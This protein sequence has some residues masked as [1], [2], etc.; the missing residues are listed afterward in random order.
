MIHILPYC[1]CYLFEDCTY[2]ITFYCAYYLSSFSIIL[3]GHILPTC[4]NFS[5]IVIDKP[6]G[7]G[8]TGYAPASIFVSHLCIIYHKK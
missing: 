6:I 4:T 3:C 2:D 5:V 1:V 8:G 7:L